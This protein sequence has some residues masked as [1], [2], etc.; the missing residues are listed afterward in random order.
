M[1]PA[2]EQNYLRAILRRARHG[3]SRLFAG[4]LGP[5]LL[6]LSLVA[7]SVVALAAAPLVPAEGVALVFF[8]LGSV[9]TYVAFR[10]SAARCW[11]T[12]ARYL[13]QQAIEARLTELG[14]ELTLEVQRSE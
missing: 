12:H 7:I 13:N 14:G 11:P 1:S 8:A 9:F 2:Q 10:F 5:S 6:W 3:P 4:F